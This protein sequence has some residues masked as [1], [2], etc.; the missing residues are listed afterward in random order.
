M[1]AV[2]NALPAC[3]TENESASRALLELVPA[4]CWPVDPQ[5]SRVRGSEILLTSRVQ[6]PHTNAIPDMQ[7][8]F[9]AQQLISSPPRDGSLWMRP[10]HRPSFSAACIGVMILLVTAL[11]DLANGSLQAGKR[12]FLDVWARVE[13]HACTRLARR[14]L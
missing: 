9:A 7:C 3:V 8:Q 6:E 5:N 13:A 2:L 11:C 12:L 1:F 14:Q 4:Q 10:P